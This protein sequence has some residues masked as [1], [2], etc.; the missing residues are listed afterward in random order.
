MFHKTG[1]NNFYL[2][3][4]NSHMLRVDGPVL[5]WVF[6]VVMKKCMYL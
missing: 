6:K 2:A 5:K 4:L 3:G 1:G